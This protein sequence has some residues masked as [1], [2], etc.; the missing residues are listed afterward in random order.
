MSIQVFKNIVS[1]ILQFFQQV[2]S[3]WNCWDATSRGV[4]CTVVDEGIAGGG[5]QR[6]ELHMAEAER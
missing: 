1:S 3:F 6:C 4:D 5:L 2:H